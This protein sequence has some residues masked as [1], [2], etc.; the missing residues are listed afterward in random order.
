MNSALK[1]F[2]WVGYI[3]SVICILIIFYQHYTRDTLSTIFPIRTL[4]LFTFIGLLASSHLKV[5]KVILILVS[6]GIVFNMEFNFDERLFGTN[7]RLPCLLNPVF[8]LFNVEDRFI[9]STTVMLLYFTILIVFLFLSF[10]N[11]KEY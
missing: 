1:Y 3:I 10:K 6:F 11:K 2:R 7:Q 4:L 9:Y 5:I 8:E